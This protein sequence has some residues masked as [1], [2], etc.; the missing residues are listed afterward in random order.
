MKNLQHSAPDTPPVSG[1]QGTGRLLS[2]AKTRTLQQARA[3][4]REALPVD[5]EE[6]RAE[7]LEGWGRRFVGDVQS[8]VGACRTE[9]HQHCLK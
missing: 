9:D 8:N 5:S 4:L 2:V 6:A 1:S 3:D 7:W